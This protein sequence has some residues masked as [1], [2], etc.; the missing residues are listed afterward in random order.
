M[1]LAPPGFEAGAVSPRDHHAEGRKD[2]LK[3]FVF[4]KPR[5]MTDAVNALVAKK[6]KDHHIDVLST[7]KY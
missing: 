3:A 4:V 1:T 2:K 7:G 6:L 5:A